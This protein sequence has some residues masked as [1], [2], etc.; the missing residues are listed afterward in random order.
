M[1]T[2]GS[3]L[4]R[5]VIDDELEVVDFYQAI[6]CFRF[7][8]RK[9]TVDLVGEKLDHSVA[10]KVLAEFRQE[11]Y[12]PISILGIEHCNKKKPYYIMLSEGNI[13]KKP[14]AAALDQRLKENFH[15]ELARSALCH[16][17]IS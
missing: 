5:Y 16:Q 9:M 1:I 12:L 15:Y 2:T 14:S 7:L 6:P 8:G 4:I 3:G 17:A 13:H 11:D 10:V